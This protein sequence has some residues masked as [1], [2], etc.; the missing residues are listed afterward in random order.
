MGQVT[1]EQGATPEPPS[2]SARSELGRVRTVNEDSLLARYPVYLVADGMGGHA[3]GD[4][5]S[6]SAREVL[7]SLRTE[8]L[9]RARARDVAFFS[10]YNRFLASKVCEVA[11]RMLS[12]NSS[13]VRR[14]NDG[15]R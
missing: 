7:I 10:R 4:L 12:I 11:T 3:R 8:G 9:P 6:R 15:E 13:A 2:A 5:A 1:V 14:R